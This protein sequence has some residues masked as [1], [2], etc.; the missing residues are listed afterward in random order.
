MNSGSASA[1]KIK[2]ENEMV[3]LDQIQKRVRNGIVELEKE[4][5][6]VQSHRVELLGEG[7]L[8]T[9]NSTDESF[10]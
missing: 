9:T 2:I 7:S 4:E 8:P 3:K 10:E 6:K 5:E 1:S